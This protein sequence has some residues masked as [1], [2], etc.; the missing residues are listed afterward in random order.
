MDVNEAIQKVREI[1]NRRPPMLKDEDILEVYN[2]CRAWIK[3]ASKED[4]E[5][6]WRKSPWESICIMQDG[7]MRK[8]DPNYDPVKEENA[9]VIDADIYRKLK[10]L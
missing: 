6:F 9:I 10:G 2:E 7:I 1:F 5:I 8:I 3:S 4:R